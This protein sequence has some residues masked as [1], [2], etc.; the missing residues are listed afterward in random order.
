MLEI[1]DG[2]RPQTPAF[3]RFQVSIDAALTGM[4]P[5]AGNAWL[6]IEVRARHGFLAFQQADKIADAIRLISPVELWN[7]V[8]TR[9]ARL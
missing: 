8:A 7:E 9:L 6:E 2:K 5:S 1:L 4:T 3:G